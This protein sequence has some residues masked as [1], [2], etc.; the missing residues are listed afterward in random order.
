MGRLEKAL[1]MKANGNIRPYQIHLE[2]LKLYFE[3]QYKLL[4]EFEKNPE[5]L[6]ENAA[7]LMDWGRTLSFILEQM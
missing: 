6:K 4:Q 5:K 3:R 2:K 1:C 7:I